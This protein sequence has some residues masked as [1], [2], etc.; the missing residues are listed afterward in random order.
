MSF[1]VTPTGATLGAVVEG[2]DPNTLSDTDSV[3]LNQAF[4]DHQVLAFRGVHLDPDSQVALTRVFGEPEAHGVD[5]GDA[6]NTEYADD[7]QLVT[8]IRSELA[9]ADVWHTDATFRDE[10]PMGALLALT[11]LPDRGGDTMWLNMYRAWDTLEPALQQV[12]ETH[13]AVH[14]QPPI[15][16]RATHP[17]VRTHPVS[18]RKALYVNRGWTRDIEGFSRKNGRALLQVLFEH[19]EQPENMMRWNWS[20]GDAVLWDNRCTMHYAIADYGESRRGGHRVILKGDMPVG[21]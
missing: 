10:P 8:I 20:E 17:M 2:L 15:T 18:G 21:V 11:H 1:S 5:G 14:G 4:T 6:R 13:R 3:T 19:A 12:C 9:K 7:N 16:G